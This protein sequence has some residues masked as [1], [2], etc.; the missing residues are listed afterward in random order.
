MSSDFS[1]EQH[2]QTDRETDRQTDRQADGQTETTTYP[3]IYPLHAENSYKTWTL[4]CT[5]KPDG[6]NFL[7][8]QTLYLQEVLTVPN[9]L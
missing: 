9:N 6:K 3:H 5:Y 8:Q 1:D 2:R 7:L 4:E